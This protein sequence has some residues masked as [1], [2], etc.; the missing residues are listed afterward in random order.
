VCPAFES[1]YGHQNQWVTNDF[2]A[3]YLCL[4]TKFAPMDY[5]TVQN[6]KFYFYI[7]P[8]YNIASMC[9]ILLPGLLNPYYLISRRNYN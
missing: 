3:H 2:A 8:K 5:T 9:G 1:R 7:S 6:K 4:L